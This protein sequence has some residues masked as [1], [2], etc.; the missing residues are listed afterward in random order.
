L[1]AKKKAPGAHPKPFDP[2]TTPI[3]VIVDV[4]WHDYSRAV[5]KGPVTSQALKT[6][7]V[8][9]E[10]M[11]GGKTEEDSHSK[12]NVG[13]KTGHPWLDFQEVVMTDLDSAD[14]SVLVTTMFC[15]W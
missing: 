5:L 1:S 9:R 15:K 14:N 4:L 13:W 10:R 3:R 2:N 12:F 11:Q 6:M 7:V 8:Q